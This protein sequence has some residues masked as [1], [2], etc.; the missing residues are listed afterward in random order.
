MSATL[1]LLLLFIASSAAVQAQDAALQAAP[2][3]N[4]KDI[5]SYLKDVEAKTDA[6]CSLENLA[7]FKSMNP[8]TLELAQKRKAYVL[9]AYE[10]LRSSPPPE[11]APTPLQPPI[12]E[13]TFAAWL[14]DAKDLKDVETR[15]LQARNNA[16][17]QEKKSPVS[18][19]REKEIATELASNQSKLATLEKI[20]DPGQF[21]CFWGEGCGV[22]FDASVPAVSGA[23][24]RSA[25]TPEDYA[26]ANAEA[27]DQTRVRGGRLDNGVSDFGAVA[28]DAFANT[29]MG[30][31]RDKTSDGNSSP[32]GTAA[33]T[34]FGLTGGLLLFGGLAGPQ[35]EDQYPNIRRNIG[36]AAGA[37]GLFAVG[38]VSFSAFPAATA[39]AGAPAV[40]AGTLTPA[41][42]GGGTVEGS[43][44]GLSMAQAFWRT[45]GLG[46][47]VLALKTGY[48]QLSAPIAAPLSQFSAGASSPTGISHVFPKDVAYSGSPEPIYAKPPHD[49]KDPDG[50]KA[51]GK[52][53]KAEGFAGPKNGEQW[54]QAKN[55]E[56]GWVDDEGNVWVPTG[57]G[58][59][60]HGGPHWDV[61]KPNGGYENVY[62]GGRRR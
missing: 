8:G 60:A 6:D 21:N 31:L 50:A 35:L 2:D 12:N 23:L 41:L 57:K 38:A 9:K 5:C 33:L 61:Q 59:R 25:W 16:L 55:G 51:P 37:A 11:T 3:E 53:G 34:A 1:S 13:R 44:S 48:E 49:A 26:R 27:R 58:N 19:E 42:A 4:D 22:R 32:L 17:E 20:R 52:P 30:P 28:S 18:P 10:V 46:G 45:A 43:G 24:G 56:W 62:P 14:P 15:R 54:G 36:I 29:P 39:S 47:G 7:A 40:S